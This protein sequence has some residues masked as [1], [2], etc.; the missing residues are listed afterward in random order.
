MLLFRRLLENM[1][2][3]QDGTEQLRLFAEWLLQLGNGAINPINGD[4]IELPAHMC[5]PAQ[6]DTLIQWVFPQLQLN[7]H[8]SDWISE[9]AILAPTNTAVDDINSRVS[10]ILPG[11]A[12]LCT[13]ADSTL[14]NDDAVQ[15]PVEYLNSITTAGLPPHRLLLKPQMPLILLRNICPSEGL[16][17]GTRLILRRVHGSILLEATIANGQHAGK[18]ALIPRMSLEPTDTTLPYKW[19]RRQFPVRVAFAMTINKAQGQTF[20]RVGVW[21]RDSV[22]THGQLYV[23]ASRVGHPERIKFSIQPDLQGRFITRN[24]VYREVL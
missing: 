5:L 18:V 10:N 9:R 14:N 15:V 16:C 8:H 1:R 12:T 2:V 17:N 23:A 3:R 21:L 13:S 24:V 7:Y 22:F 4:Y 6:I 19:Q 11:E 20:N